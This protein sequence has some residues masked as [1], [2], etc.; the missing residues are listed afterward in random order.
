MMQLYGVVQ[1]KADSIAAQFFSAGCNTDFNFY[2][3]NCHEMCSL[4]SLVM[5]VYYIFVPAVYFS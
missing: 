4:E 5:K 1:E 2:L 3:N